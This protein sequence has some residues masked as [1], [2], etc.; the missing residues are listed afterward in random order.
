MLLDA[1]GAEQAVCS[2]CDICEGIEYAPCD[3][4]IA[5]KLIKKNRNYY[6]KEDAQ[7]EHEWRMNN[8]LRKT[9]GL[10]VWNH[11]DSVETFSQLIKSGRIRTSGILWKNRL[12]A[13][14]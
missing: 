10:N 1:L 7:E 11:N 6:T 14:P 9:L 13:S 3:W 5:Y 8:I 4:E 2:G 12:K